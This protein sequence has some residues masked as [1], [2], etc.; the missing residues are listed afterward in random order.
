VC[1]EQTGKSS[2]DMFT[3]VTIKVAH[4]ARL[5]AGTGAREA[6]PKQRNLRAKRAP[7]SESERTIRKQARRH[8]NLENFP[9]GTL[10]ARRFAP[11]PSGSVTNAPHISCRLGA[12]WANTRIARV[13]FL[14]RVGTSAVKKRGSN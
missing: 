12:E 11:S 14:M 10:C 2:C 13:S 9:E 4:E 7:S 6:R 1:A 3:G 5:L 8:R